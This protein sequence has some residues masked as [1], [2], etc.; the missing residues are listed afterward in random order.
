M[1]KEMVEHQMT[2]MLNSMFDFYQCFEL[3]SVGFEWIWMAVMW[4]PLQLNA[5]NRIAVKIVV[6][7]K[8]FECRI[9]WHLCNLTLNKSVALHSYRTPLSLQIF[10]HTHTASLKWKRVEKK[11]RDNEC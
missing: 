5:L 6:M 10:D 11:T 9:R 4:R 1:K 3:E 8:T 2:R 7:V